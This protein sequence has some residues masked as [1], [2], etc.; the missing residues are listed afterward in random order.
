[1]R[2]VSAE[3]EFSY[4]LTVRSKAQGEPR[5]VDFDTLGL[6]TRVGGELGNGSGIVRQSIL[7]LVNAD[8]KKSFSFLNADSIR[9]FEIV[10]RENGIEAT[11]QFSVIVVDQAVAERA[12][13]VMVSVAA[14]AR[15]LVDCLPPASE[16][17][18]IK[19]ISVQRI[20]GGEPDASA[21]SSD[22]YLL[23]LVDRLLGH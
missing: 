23:A 20:S 22:V 8:G 17:T 19:G 10:I 21:S 11:S 1:M 2:G 9:A 15:I 18:C 13:P 3:G 16:A 14:P 5:S 6:T 12:I 7:G 4:E